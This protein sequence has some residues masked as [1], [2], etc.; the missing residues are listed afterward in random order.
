MK[1]LGQSCTVSE[2]LMEKREKY[3]CSLYG[4]SGTDV[5]DVRYALFFEKRFESS[6]LPSTKDILSKHTS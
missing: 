2:E 1:E 6:Q 5:I 4:K 3:V